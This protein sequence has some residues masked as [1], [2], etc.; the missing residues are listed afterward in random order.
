MPHN[1]LLALY[2]LL[3]F[4]TVKLHEKYETKYALILGLVFGLLVVC[5]PTEGLTLLIPLLWNVAS[6]NDFKEKIKLFASNKKL[7]LV[8][9]I[10]SFIIVL[11][12]LIY[13]KFV[14]G[15]WVITSY[16]NPAEGLDWF[17]P[18]TFD[19][20]FSFRKGWFI[21]TPIALIGVL[22]FYNLF[23]RNKFIAPAIIIFF[24]INLYVVSAWSCWWYA[25]SFSMRALVQ[26]SII[27]IF[28][29]SSS[30]EYF[31][32]NKKFKV[33]FFSLMIFL[34]GLNQ[35]QVW[36]ME[37]GIIN[38]DR[39]TAAYYFKIFAKTKIEPEWNKLLLVERSSTAIDLS[40]DKTDYFE[41]KVVFLS[42][43]ASDVRSIDTISKSG[44]RSTYVN[45]E[46]AFSSSIDIS[47]KDITSDYYGWIEGEYWIYPTENPVEK[48]FSIVYT[49]IYDNK[50]YKYRALDSEYLNLKVN[51]WNKVTFKYLTPEI[52]TVDDKFSTY[53]WN[54]GS[55]TVYIDDVKVTCF[56]EKE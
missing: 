8:F 25:S 16:G 50:A 51:E 39:M 3:I 7:L 52:R 38:G 14:G 43:E 20:L 37:R 47:V 11:P 19:V 28:P 22:S 13:W 40:F 21:Y 31:I 15:S 53:V 1:L 36:Q 41:T 29:L 42:F 48:P 4:F 49:F 17:S 56:Q 18:H 10:S 35:F 5:R 34:V 55:Q 2:C 24:I 12:Q 45:K 23:K 26:S 32:K 46:V 33:A 6:I 27:L 54:R 9:T 30:V 44:H